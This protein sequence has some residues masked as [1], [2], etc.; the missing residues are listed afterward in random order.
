MRRAVGVLVLVLL[1]G[2][3]SQR[4]QLCMVERAAGAGEHL[5]DGLVAEMAQPEAYMRDVREQTR[6][7]PEGRLFP[8]VMPTLALLNRVSADPS[9]REEALAVVEPLM[10]PMLDELTD[11]VRPPND[12]LLQ[13]EHTMGHGTWIGQSA[14]ALGA[15]RRLG[16]TQHQEVHAHLVELLAQALDEADGGPIES[17]PG[18]TWAFDTVPAALALRL[19]DEALG[20]QAHDARIARHLAWVRVEGRDP[21]SGLPASVLT[22]GPDGWKMQRGPRGC[23]LMLRIGLLAQLD[24]EA[25]WELYEPVAT[26]LWRGGP[27]VAGFAEWPGR[28]ESFGDFDSGPVVLGRGSVASG[29]GLGA[30]RAVGDRR[31]HDVLVAE[32]ATVLW[33]LP[34]VVPAVAMMPGL[35]D[36]P[37][38]QRWHTGFLFGDAALSWAVTWEDWGVSRSSTG[39]S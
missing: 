2:L 15:Y 31:R 12:D 19:H 23:E 13:L 39:R 24:R 38:E 14:L 16:G 35:G 26:E 17:Y 34:P 4:A 28:T 36:T 27:G 10:Q 1:V 30:A 5:L 20:I 29:F 7:F 11:V 18:L 6:A 8:V 33:L 22:R 25:A 37:L 9:R 3:M 21:T 32:L